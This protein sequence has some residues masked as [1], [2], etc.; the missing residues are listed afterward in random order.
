MLSDRRQINSCYFVICEL[1]ES[2]FP[3]LLP[4]LLSLQFTIQPNINEHEALVIYPVFLFH[5]Y[6][7][8]HLLS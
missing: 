2:F 3:T 4:N 8:K 1:L 6:L 5:H 7:Q